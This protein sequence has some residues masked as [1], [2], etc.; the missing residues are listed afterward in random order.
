[1]ELRDAGVARAFAVAQLR[2]HAPASHASYEVFSRGCGELTF[3][4]LMSTEIRYFI[5]LVGLTGSIG[6]IM[7]GNF[8][9]QVDQHGLGHHDQEFDGPEHLNSNG[10]RGLARHIPHRNGH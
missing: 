3:S 1:M 2:L 6:W 8:F 5:G 4:R 7:N 10:S 9:V